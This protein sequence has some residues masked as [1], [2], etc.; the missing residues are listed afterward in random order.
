M[1]RRH[2]FNKYKHWGKCVQEALLQWEKF[3]RGVWR[4]AEKIK[5]NVF[6]SIHYL[7]NRALNYNAMIKIF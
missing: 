3:Y 6:H 7:K 2:I 5:K 4:G 1:I